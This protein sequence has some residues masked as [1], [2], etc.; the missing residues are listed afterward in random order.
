MTLGDR[1]RH[2]REQRGLLQTELADRI[3]VSKQTLYKYETGIITNIPSDKIESMAKVFGVSEAHIM[4]WE[5]V[6]TDIKLTVMN[7]R[8]K[9]YALK[10]SELSQ[11]KQEHIMSLIDLLGEKK[12]E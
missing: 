1:I 7:E 4:G 10:L 3:G 5:V 11:D 8:L 2:L 12:G 9:L 6:D